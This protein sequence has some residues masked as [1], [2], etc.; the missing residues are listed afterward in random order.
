LGID[1]F[2]GGILLSINLGFNQR[3]QRSYIMDGIFIQGRRPKSKAEIRDFLMGNAKKGI[4]VTMPEKVVVECTSMFP[5]G[6]DGCVTTMNVGQKVT[7]VG[8][9]PYTKRSFYGSIKRLPDV[10]GQMKFKVE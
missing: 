4:L 1:C 5:G 7:F 9:D 10:N 3:S 6:F 8:P 2:T